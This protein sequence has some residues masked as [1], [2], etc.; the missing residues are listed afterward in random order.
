MSMPENMLI[1]HLKNILFGHLYKFYLNSYSNTLYLLQSYSVEEITHQ[2]DI[3]TTTFSIIY[4]R[5][6]YLKHHFMLMLYCDIWK[7]L[8][9]HM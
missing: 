2:L 8:S 1:K 9:K 4:Y 3:H 7:I 6:Q 5:V